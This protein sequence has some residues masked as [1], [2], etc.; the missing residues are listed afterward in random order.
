MG[1]LNLIFFWKQC[2]Y[3]TVT[4]VSVATAQDEAG[5]AEPSRPVKKAKVKKPKPMANDP[6]ITMD[7]HSL[8]PKLI[9]S[10][11]N[12]AFQKSLFSEYLPYQRFETY[13][14]EIVK[15]ASDGK[16]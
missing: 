9:N 11:E 8:S 1:A 14:L 6:A 4:K 2:Q 10:E 13:E 15:I 5:K 7:L 3:T 12:M 16:F